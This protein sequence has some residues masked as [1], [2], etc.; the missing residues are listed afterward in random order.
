MTTDERIAALVK[1]APPMS[2]E[3]RARLAGLFRSTDR[4]REARAS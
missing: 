1:S 3:Q 4:S 2:P